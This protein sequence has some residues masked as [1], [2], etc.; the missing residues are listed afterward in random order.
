MLNAVQMIVLIA[1][2]TAFEAPDFQ[3]LEIDLFFTNFTG[4][5]VM[6]HNKDDEVW[7]LQNEAW[8]IWERGAMK[9][10]KE[11]LKEMKTHLL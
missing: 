2:C 9:S 6:A 7:V 3:I 8:T 5:D 4:A 11:R 10:D 1:F